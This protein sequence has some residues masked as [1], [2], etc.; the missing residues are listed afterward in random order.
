MRR[1]FLNYDDKSFSI[2]LN[3]FAI[4]FEIESFTECIDPKIYL[5]FFAYPSPYHN[6]YSVVAHLRDLLSSPSSNS[7]LILISK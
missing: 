2:L 1:I 6:T 4:F 5:S 7:D 3:Y